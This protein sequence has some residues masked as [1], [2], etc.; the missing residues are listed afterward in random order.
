[1]SVE[2]INPSNPSMG[3]MQKRDFMKKLFLFTV[4]ILMAS[5]SESPAP[6]IQQDPAMI[7]MQKTIQDAEQALK[8]DNEKLNVPAARDLIS[9]YIAYA[10]Q[11]HHDTLAG[12]FLL[13]AASLS[14]GTGN[15]PQAVDLLINYYDGFPVG[16]RHAEAAFTVAFVYDEYLKDADRAAK[17][18][19]AV[20][21]NHPESEYARQAEGALRL[22]GMSDEELLKFLE[23]KNP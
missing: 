2:A 21:D 16:K 9:Q 19:Q 4:V 20:I 12:E 7:A 6:T 11:Y 15:Y 3:M 13:R 22:V 17:Y 14:V 8:L 23:G 18:Y 1:M 10:N 5:C